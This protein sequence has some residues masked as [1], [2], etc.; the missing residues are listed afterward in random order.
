M[1]Q[2]V[3]IGNGI[4]GITAA[5]YIRKK[6]NLNITVI[7]DE[8]S[9]FFSRTALM[10]VYMGHMKFSQTQ[11]YENWFWKKN[12]INLLQSRVTSVSPDINK[13]KLD[14]GEHI[15]YSKLIIAS[16]SKYNMLNWPGKDLKGVS[17]LY[18]K[19]DLDHITKLTQTCKNAVIIGGGLIG[20]E[21]TEMLLSKNIRVT[22]VCREKSFWNNALTD[23]Q[24]QLINNHIKSHHINLI[25]NDTLKS[26]EGEKGLVKNVLLESGLKIPCEFVGITIGV[27]P[28]I[29]FIKDSGINF[30]K[31][32]LV[33]EFLSTNYPN[34]YAIGDCAE[35]I[36]PPNNRPKIESI[37]YSGRLMGETVAN[38]I[39]ESKTKYKPGHWFNSAKFL[40]IEYQ[41][42]GKVN[43]TKSISKGN[44]QFNWNNYSKSVNITIQYI[45]S[46]RQ[47]TGISA[48][49]IRLRQEVIHKWLDEKKDIHFTIKNFDKILFD[50]EFSTNY[51][52]QI[53]KTYNEIFK[54]NL[55]HRS[56]K[57]LSFLNFK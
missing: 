49:G 7:S 18:H 26:I 40:D 47:I 30:D 34:V 29:D 56:N 17:G 6:S 50:P 31:G 52:N 41:I 1:D 22:L 57:I 20:I 51:Y 8:H 45:I 15:S 5:R 42:Y 32:I 54:V 28:N 12:N 19:Q 37:W 38:T 36:I 43:N 10:Y 24:S 2:V 35:H 25:F 39:T 44:A 55:K 23:D 46:N 14:N 4:S 3:I 53:I 48:L 9:Y 33:N 21:L 13:L 16:G 11:P 27:S